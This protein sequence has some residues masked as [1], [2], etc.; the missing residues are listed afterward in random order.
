MSM[1]KSTYDDADVVLLGPGGEQIAGT[2]TG[3]VD[4]DANTSEATYEFDFTAQAGDTGGWSFRFDGPVLDNDGAP[5]PTNQIIF[6][7]NA[8]V[9]PAPPTNTPPSIVST[10]AT[11]RGAAVS[12][13]DSITQAGSGKFIIKVRYTDPE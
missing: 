7:F 11:Y 9:P 13:G 8:A 3:N 1:D 12:T 10:T 6:L 2:Y 5:V 4:I